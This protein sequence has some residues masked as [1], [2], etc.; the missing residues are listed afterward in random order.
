VLPVGGALN[1]TEGERLATWLRYAKAFGNV[2]AVAFFFSVITLFVGVGLSAFD[3][4]AAWA[5]PIFAGLLACGLAV[6]L[7]PGKP[8][9]YLLVVL[10]SALHFVFTFIVAYIAL[11]PFV[12]EPGSIAFAAGSI[13]TACVALGLYVDSRENALGKSAHGTVRWSHWLFGLALA[14]TLPFALVA[15]GLALLGDD[16]QMR[17]AEGAAGG[18]SIAGIL[19]AAAR[20]GV[21]AAVKIGLGGRFGGGGAERLIVTFAAARLLFD[22]SFSCTTSPGGAAGSF[23]SGSPEGYPTPKLH[24]IPFSLR[25]Q[26]K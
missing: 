5:A 10:R 15:L 8:A 1:W 4:E 24:F 25:I 3:D 23:G 12:R 7:F 26:R 16:V 20:Y 18:G 6:F 17:L 11:Q 13:I 22:Y 9:R 14:M 21:F 2:I 19:W